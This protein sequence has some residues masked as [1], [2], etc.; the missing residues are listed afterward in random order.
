MK[1][2]EMRSGEC[3]MEYG[4]PSES[5]PY[6]PRGTTTPPLDEVG[7]RRKFFDLAC[8]RIGRPQAEELLNEIFE[9]ELTT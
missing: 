6:S 7:M 5:G 2:G 8:R 1:S 4:M 9:R 3:R